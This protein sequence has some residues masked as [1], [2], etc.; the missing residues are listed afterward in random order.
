M[1][2]FNF[3]T[4]DFSESLDMSI[5]TR[6]ENILKAKYDFERFLNSLYKFIEPNSN[7]QWLG[8]AE[9][10]AYRMKDEYIFTKEFLKDVVSLFY[11][12]Q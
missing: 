5:K 12:L 1:N 11:L 10:D 7:W 3:P 8:F 2:I 4:S 9:K 6:Q